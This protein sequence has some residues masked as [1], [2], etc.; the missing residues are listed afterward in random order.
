MPILPW[1]LYVVLGLAVLASWA[2]VG[3]AVHRGEL[4]WRGGGA[5]RRSEDP[6]VF[7]LAVAGMLAG[8]L[9][10]VTLIAV[11]IVLTW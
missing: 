11:V 6:L 8:T 7:W 10:A 4:R 9:T 2:V 1:A 5:L 3:R